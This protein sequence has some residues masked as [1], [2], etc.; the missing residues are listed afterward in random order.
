MSPGDSAQAFRISRS[1]SSSAAAAARR[2]SGVAGNFS[3]GQ[4]SRGQSKIGKYCVLR[5]SAVLVSDS[6]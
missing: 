4:E 2:T 5:A 1:T 6:A 3:L